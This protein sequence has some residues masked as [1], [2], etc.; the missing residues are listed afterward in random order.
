MVLAL[1]G[2]P[3]AVTHTTSPASWAIL[4]SF[5]E[6]TSS[7]IYRTFCWPMASPLAD[8][9][10]R[11]W[12]AFTASM[13][14]S[15]SPEIFRLDSRFTTDTSSSCSI[16]R[17]FSSNRPNRLT[18]SSIRS[19]L[20]LCSVIGISFCLPPFHVKHLFVFT[21]PPPAPPSGEAWP[22]TALSPRPPRPPGAYRKSGPRSRP[23]PRCGRSPPGTPPAA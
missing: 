7:M 6:R 17:M 13:T 21:A 11:P 4:P 8:R 16:R 10:S 15:P 14:F 19:M 9:V 12:M 1:M 2:L 23:A 5:P 18:A 20:M 3:L 22:H